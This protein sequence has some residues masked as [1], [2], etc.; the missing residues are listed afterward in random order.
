NLAEGA[1]EAT[2]ATIR[3]FVANINTG[4]L[5]VTGFLGLVVTRMLTL[6][7]VEKSINRVWN[8]PITRPVF[9]RVA[10]YWFFITLGPLAAAAALG[11]ASSIGVGASKFA[12]PTLLLFPI[13]IGAFF[14]MYKFIPHRKVHWQ[15]AL[16]A[17]FW[18]SLSWL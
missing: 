12:P 5:G 4:T 17:A 15:P 8:A 14:G 7:S 11:F 10:T 3:S 13:L 18:T 6:S 1:D 16:I 9:Q 2:L